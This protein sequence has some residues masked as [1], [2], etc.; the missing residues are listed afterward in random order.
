MASSSA[1]AR[2]RSRSR[3]R[4][5]IQYNSPLVSAARAGRG[6]T[7]AITTSTLTLPLR[8][9]R[10]V[11]LKSGEPGRVDLRGEGVQ[12]GRKGCGKRGGKRGGYIPLFFVTADSKGL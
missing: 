5:S 9:R 3:S 8:S 4:R 10:V 12:T 7:A 6:K 1:A 2:T 11:P